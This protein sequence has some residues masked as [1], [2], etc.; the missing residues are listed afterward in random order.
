MLVL[1]ASGVLLAGDLL[2]DEEVP[3]LDLQAAD[4]VGDH[5]RTLDMVESLVAGHGIGTLVPGHGTLAR[6]PEI[7]R[8][9]A[10]DRRYLTALA[11]G[12][13]VHDDRLG[14]AEVRGLHEEQRRALRAP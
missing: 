7:T 14:S 11:T 2:S 13:D 12:D 3:L 4:P 5:L 9:V 1:P 8:R 6:G 10:A